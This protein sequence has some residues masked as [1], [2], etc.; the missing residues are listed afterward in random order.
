[1]DIEI[2]E[3]EIDY[4][5]EEKRRI[6]LIIKSDLF[7]NQALKNFNN[8]Y[9]KQVMKNPEM[10]ESYYKMQEELK[11]IVSSSVKSGFNAGKTFG[12]HTIVYKEKGES[13][14][15]ATYEEVY[16]SRINGNY[17]GD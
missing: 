17:V 12:K 2:V 1:M 7:I 13:G 9:L 4:T 8:M 14:I 3:K 11:I 15:K 5:E 6:K 10:R 16:G